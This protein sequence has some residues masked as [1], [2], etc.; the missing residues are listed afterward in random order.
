LEVNEFEVG[1][2][3]EEFDL[4]NFPFGTAPPLDDAP[5]QTLAKSK[6]NFFTEFDFHNLAIWMLVNP[7]Q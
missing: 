1:I 7:V 2:F 3:T 6:V 4:M 5:I